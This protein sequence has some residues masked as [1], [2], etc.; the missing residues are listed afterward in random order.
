MQ[1]AIRLPNA[2]DNGTTMNPLYPTLISDKCPL[3]ISEAITAAEITVRTALIDV[4]TQT[5]RNTD[6]ARPVAFTFMP[7][8]LSMG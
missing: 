5:A 3:K 2:T 4:P 8:P 1:N 6:V 7:L